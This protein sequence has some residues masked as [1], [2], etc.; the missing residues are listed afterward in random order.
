MDTVPVV[1]GKPSAVME[2]VVAFPIP[3]WYWS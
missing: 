2:A 3:V 1:H